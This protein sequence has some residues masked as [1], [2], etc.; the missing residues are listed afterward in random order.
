MET[1][2][3]LWTNMPLWRS[4]S[5][6]RDTESLQPFEGGQGSCSTSV[7]PNLSASCMTLIRKPCEKT[8][9]LSQTRTFL[10]IKRM[11]T[12]LFVSPR[13]CCCCGEWLPGSPRCARATWSVRMQLCNKQQGNR[14]IVHKGSTVMEEF[15]HN[16]RHCYRLRHTCQTCQIVTTFYLN[17]F[18]FR[19]C[20]CIYIYTIHLLW[21]IL[22]IF[23]VHIY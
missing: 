17:Q 12:I 20:V 21:P 4:G 5:S 13:K 3:R 22:Y 8:S 11:S 1:P 6:E 23:W 15:K 7:H 19:V 14:F 9:F 2:T 18:W 10:T 16:G